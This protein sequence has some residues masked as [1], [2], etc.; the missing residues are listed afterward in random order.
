MDTSDPCRCHAPVNAAMIKPGPVVVGYWVEEAQRNS[1]LCSCLINIATLGRQ[2][3]Q[4]EAIGA[5]RWN[6]I[7]SSHLS[8]FLPTCHNDVALIKVTK[9]SLFHNNTW[10]VILFAVMLLYIQIWTVFEIVLNIEIQFILKLC[11]KPIYR[12]A[13]TKIFAILVLKNT[14]NEYWKI[15]TSISTTISAN[16]GLKWYYWV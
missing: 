14:K 9:K 15:G 10:F 16:I 6:Q 13:F 5:M 4:I 7:Y 8:L 11:N 2:L 1:L 3:L 12:I